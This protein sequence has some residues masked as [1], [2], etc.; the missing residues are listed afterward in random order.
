ML[1]NDSTD[2]SDMRNRV[3]VAK[4]RARAL[5]SNKSLADLEAE[6]GPTT[7]VDLSEELVDRSAMKE[8]VE[9]LTTQRKRKARRKAAPDEKSTTPGRK[10][11]RRSRNNRTDRKSKNNATL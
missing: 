10:G 6:E 8:A 4:M 7:E 2:L 11:G 1:G 3:K 9:M 5:R